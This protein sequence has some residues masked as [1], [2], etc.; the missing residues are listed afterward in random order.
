MRYFSSVANSD[1][2]Q[3]GI[4]KVFFVGYKSSSF[5]SVLIGITSFNGHIFNGYFLWRKVVSHPE[6]I[7]SKN[8]FCDH[9]V[10]FKCTLLLKVASRLRRLNKKIDQ[11]CIHSLNYI[12]FDNRNNVCYIKTAWVISNVSTFDS[13]RVARPFGITS[14]R[15]C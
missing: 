15:G 2:N 12:E 5:W 1:W 10:R 11:I 13:G 9:F 6:C 8:V 3:F 7:D 4:F 14:W